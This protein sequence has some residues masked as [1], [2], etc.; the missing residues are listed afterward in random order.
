NGSYT[1]R[2]TSTDQAGNSTVA[3]QQVTVGHF[4]ASQNA[5]EINIAA[6]GTI[7]YNSAV[8]YTMAETITIKSAT[9]DAVVR[10][11][12][13]AVQ[14][15]AGTYNDV[16]DGRNDQGALVGDGAYRIFAT[17]TDG[18]NTYTWDL[19]GKPR[20]AAGATTDIDGRTAV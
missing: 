19:T 6:N 3:T 11:L 7:T 1:L 4:S 2:L 16:W 13:S 18:T 17:L 9:T 14:R 10:T 8:P 15:T 12:V 20:A 5:Y